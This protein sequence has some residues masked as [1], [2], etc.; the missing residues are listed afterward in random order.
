MG[1]IKLQTRLQRVACVDKNLHLTSVVRYSTIPWEDIVKFACENSGIP[2][3]QMAAFSYAITQQ[4]EQFI[5]N[6]HSLE[7]GTLGTWYLSAKAKGMEDAKE[8]GADAVE[9]ISLKFRQSK[10]MRELLATNVTLS[11]LVS[12]EASDS[13]DDEE[14]DTENGGTGG[15][16]G[17]NDQTEDPLA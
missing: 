12:S 4:V 16:T 9:S 13:T 15:R 8:A 11:T 6:G 10:R 1:T 14:E 7:F 2:K 5:L 17:G 3:A